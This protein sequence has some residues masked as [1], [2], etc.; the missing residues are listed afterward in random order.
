MKQNDLLPLIE[1]EV[2]STFSLEEVRAMTFENFF[3]EIDVKNAYEE[4]WKPKK[5]KPSYF[6]IYNKIKKGELK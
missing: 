4:G 5:F 2:R 3:D 6:V 1:E